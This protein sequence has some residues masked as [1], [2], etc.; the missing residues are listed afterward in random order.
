[1][2]WF[3]LFIIVVFIY[4]AFVPADISPIS[5]EDFPNTLIQVKVSSPEEAKKLID[6][7]LQVEL[8]M[9]INGVAEGFISPSN[10]KRVRDAGFTVAVVE[11]LEG[12]T[13]RKP[14]YDFD[15]VVSLLTGWVEDYPEMT[16]F[17]TAGYSINGEPVLQFKISSLPDT[18]ARQRIYFSGSTH[19]NEKIGT[20][21]CMLIISYLLENYS[22]DP[23]VKELVD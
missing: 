1:M 15:D 23:D 22:T 6:L 8:N 9:V 20:E 3:K 4:I 14:W 5:N 12:Q 21:T 13:G 19:G 7:G 18:A 16:H 10:L 2:K 11:P 17:D